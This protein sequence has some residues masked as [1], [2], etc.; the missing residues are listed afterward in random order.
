MR[1]LARRRRTSATVPGRGRIAQD[2]GACHSRLL[3][4]GRS[5]QRPRLRIAVATGLRCPGTHA[6]WT[7]PADVRTCDVLTSHSCAGGGGN[8]SRQRDR[9]CADGRNRP[10]RR[11]RRVLRPRRP[12]VRITTPHVPGMVEVID[13]LRYALMSAWRR[14]PAAAHNG[15]TSACGV[16]GAKRNRDVASPFRCV[17]CRCRALVK[18]VRHV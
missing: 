10:H 13:D 4:S 11:R 18:E 7:S 8:R 3:R 1:I 14:S 16:D 6:T 5:G 2:G 17:P 15:R 9:V 12:P